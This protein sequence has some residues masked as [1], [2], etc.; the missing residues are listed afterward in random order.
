MKKKRK[1]KEIYSPSATRSLSKSRQAEEMTRGVIQSWKV[2]KNEDLN[3]FSHQWEHA[4][5]LQSI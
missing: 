5:K 3:L 1:K 2:A 4:C